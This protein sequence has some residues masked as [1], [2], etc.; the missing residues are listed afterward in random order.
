MTAPPCAPVLSRDEAVSWRAGERAAGRRVVFTNGC[1][2][3]LH[4]GHLAVLEAA[5]AAGDALIVALNT[6]ASVGRLKGAGRPLVPAAERA[7]VIAALRCVDAV[8]LFDEDT[9]AALIEALVPDVLA[10]GGDYTAASV[11]GHHTVESAGG[12]VLIVPL[13]PGHSTTRLAAR[14]GSA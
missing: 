10:K 5:R 1:F 13:V 12:R 9:P 11:V 3:L 4:V 2:D 7:A 8:T 6:D 14:D